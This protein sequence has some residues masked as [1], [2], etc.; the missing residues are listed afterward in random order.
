M[1]RDQGQ[2]DAGNREG[3]AGGGDT[4]PSA[5]IPSGRRRR[6]L[7]ALA[8]LGVLGLAAG[9]GAY[10]RHH[11]HAEPQP[12]AASL[13]GL[14]PA[15]AAA[16]EEARRA[17]QKLPQSAGAWG[18]LG[19]VLFA[20]RFRAEA[21]TCFTRA[22]Q[23]DARDPRWPFFQGKLLSLKDSETAIPKFRRAAELCGD[24]PDTPR[25]RLAELLLEQGSPGE[26]GTH[27]NY[28]LRRHP[29]HPVAH[30]G[31]ARL[32]YERDDWPGCLRHLKECTAS[33]FSQKAARTLMATVYARLGDR[34]AANRQRDLSTHLPED[35][36]WPD[37]FSR[38]LAQF[39]LDKRSRL[40]AGGQLL[41][42]HRLPEAIV[43]LSD[44]VRDEP[45]LYAAW[46]DLGYAY[47][48]AED[49]ANAEWALHVALR[50]E[51]DSAEGHYYL[52]CTA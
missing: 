34:P 40:M 46:R 20:A 44:L 8:I 21:E 12:P 30:L 11:Q 18:R 17:V 52:G 38:E 26:A 14:E 43:T 24:Q 15:V 51:P 33:P 23:L 50:L 1:A 42:Q 3:T 49:Y 41:A 25:L 37:P 45:D 2:V 22:E 39:R 36:P 32:A 35:R 19:M 29:S 16:V 6:V 48:Q 7:V 47:F 13:E 9:I 28:L 10:V 4:A 27:F 31:L 5:V